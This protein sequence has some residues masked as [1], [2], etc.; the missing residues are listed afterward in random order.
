MAIVKHRVQPK[1]V[2]RKAVSQDMI[3]KLLMLK[4][5]KRQVAHAKKD[6]ETAKPEAGPEKVAKPVE[7][8]PEPVA[9]TTDEVSVE[10]TVFE[11]PKK[12]AKRSSRKKKDAETEETTENNEQNQ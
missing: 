5:A 8:M 11:E 7:T 3:E 10:E 1:R 6:K 2:Y 12:P 4:R 9:E